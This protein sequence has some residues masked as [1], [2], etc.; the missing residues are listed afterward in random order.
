LEVIYLFIHLIIH[1]FQFNL[2]FN[3]PS[4]SSHV[5]GKGTLGCFSHLPKKTTT[6]TSKQMNER[7]KKRN[8]I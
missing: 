4:L 8:E 1:L 5:G 2:V 3:F 7:N 6:T